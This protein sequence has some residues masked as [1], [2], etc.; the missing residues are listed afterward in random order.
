[1]DFFSHVISNYGIAGTMVWDSRSICEDEEY[2]DRLMYVCHDVV[3][4]VNKGFS[5]FFWGWFPIKEK[6]ILEEFQ[7]CTERAWMAMIVIR[8][9]V[10]R[11][12]FQGRG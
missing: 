11:I 2:V 1:M 3:L 9:L 5:G 12:R 4:F 7:C 10:F 8:K 6:T